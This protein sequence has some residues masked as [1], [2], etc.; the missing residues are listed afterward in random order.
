MSVT[1]AGPHTSGDTV[2]TLTDAAVAKLIELRD[3][4]PE[5][6]RLGLRITIVDDQGPDFQYDLSFELV[7]TT[8]ISDVIR[9]HGGLKV[10]VPA[11]DVEALTG[12]VLDIELGGLTMKNPNKPAPL[13]IGN[14]TIDDDTAVEVR[15]VIDEQVNPALASHGGY[16]TFLG[17]DGDG[18]AYLT[19]GGGCHGCAMSRLTMLE[20]V[21]RMILDTVPAV[22]KVI[23]ATDHS[24]GENPYYT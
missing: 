7:T 21:Q 23:D 22:T 14:L 5:G 4:E 9:N 15:A 24:T 2:L 1:D 6:D 3:E 12:A 20:G 19:M 17:H 18:R 8:D 16:V 10:M 13:E 11:R